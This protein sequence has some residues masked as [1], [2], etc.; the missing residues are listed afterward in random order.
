GSGVYAVARHPS[1]PR[2]AD[3]PA[4]YC[5]G[6]CQGSRRLRRKQTRSAPLREHSRHGAQV[7]QELAGAY[8][9]VIRYSLAL[10]LCCACSSLLTS[11]GDSRGRS[12]VNVI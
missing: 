7:A 2:S 10:L 4:A 12:I 6:T 11:S 8:H 1:Q 9:L 5:G 3:G